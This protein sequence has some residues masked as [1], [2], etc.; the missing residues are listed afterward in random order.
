MKTGTLLR[1]LRRRT[2]I[3]NRLARR[4]CRGLPVPDVG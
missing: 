4:I 1:H 2:E 3:P